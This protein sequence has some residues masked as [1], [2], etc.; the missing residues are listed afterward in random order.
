[1]KKIEKRKNGTI[2]VYSEN[3]LPSKTDQ[4]Q[5]A[6][7]DVNNIMAKYKKTGQITHL[8]KVQGH[9]ADLSQIQDLH[10]SM[11]QVVMAQQTFDA[12]PSELRLRFQNSPL[13]MVNFLNN[14]NNDQEAIKLGL[15]IAKETNSPNNMSS[16]Q[17][18]KPNQTPNDDEPNDDD[19]TQ[20]PKKTQPQP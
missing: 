12:L 10:T 14:P 2:R 1:M 7:T 9:F 20:K 6:Q 13:E 5:L 3:K 19:Q 16:S 8:A 17:K 18:R 11:N 4:S 15:K